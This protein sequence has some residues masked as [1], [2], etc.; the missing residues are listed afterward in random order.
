MGNDYCKGWFC[1]RPVKASGQALAIMGYLKR[2]YLM[3]HVLL[4]PI[5]DYTGGRKR[6][7]W[8]KNQKRTPWI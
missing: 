2:L 5:K 6:P 7:D 3:S 4:Y 8:E 1:R